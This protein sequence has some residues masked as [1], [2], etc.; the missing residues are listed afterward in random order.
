MTDV[1]VTGCDATGGGNGNNCGNGHHNGHDK[2]HKK[3]NQGVGNGPEGCDP[4]NSN[5]N[6]FGSNDEDDDYKPGNPG[7]KGDRR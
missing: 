3:C 5:N 7:R 1:T 2:D 4:G 6:P